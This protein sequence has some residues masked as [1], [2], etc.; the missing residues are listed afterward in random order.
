MDILVILGV[1][2]IIQM[3]KII[4]FQSSSKNKIILINDILSYFSFEFS[5]CCH[6]FVKRIS[7]EHVGF[8]VATFV[9]SFLIHRCEP[10]A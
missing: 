9:V 7:W 6:L 2:N 1:F 10:V 8:Y 5:L 4:L 3:Q